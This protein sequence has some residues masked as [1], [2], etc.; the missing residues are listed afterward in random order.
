MVR[1]ALGT[2]IGPAQRYPRLLPTPINTNSG[3]GPWVLPMINL[4]DGQVLYCGVRSATSGKCSV[5][6]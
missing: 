6:P 5:H 4:P 1:E 2:A 3:G